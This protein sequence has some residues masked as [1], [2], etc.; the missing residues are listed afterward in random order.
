MQSLGHFE[1]ERLDKDIGFDLFFQ[2]YF[3]L[4]KPVI[5]EKVGKDW[6]AIK[7]WD[8]N[9]LQQKLSEESSVFNNV[10]FFVMDE[11]T[12]GEDYIIPKVVKILLEESH[13][14]PQKINTRI[15]INSRNNVSSWHYDSNIESVFNVQIQGRKEWQLVSPDTP[16]ICYPF[17]NF[18]LLGESINILKDKIYTQ[19]ILEEGDLL[20]IPPLWFHRVSALEE[21]NVNLNWVMTKKRTEVLTKG[22]QREIERYLLDDYFRSHRCSAVKYIHRKINSYVPLYFQYRW[23]YEE[24][25][26]TNFTP[27][28]YYLVKRL[29][30]ELALLGKALLTIKQ[31]RTIFRTIDRTPSLKP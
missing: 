26:Q 25:I 3:Q 7:K 18:A 8:R 30:S 14:F 28:K 22:L 17:S 24:L 13:T 9:Y 19:F 27:S 11:N 12:L 4:E 10:L 31:I 21:I 6:P 2:K 23:R 5:I 16:L 29:F 1:I 20:Y 15:W